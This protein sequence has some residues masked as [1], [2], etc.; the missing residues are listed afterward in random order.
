MAAIH[1]PAPSVCTAG[2]A[3]PP[4]LPNDGKIDACTMARLPIRVKLINGLTEGR[5]AVEVARIALKGSAIFLQ[6]LGVS[7]R[8]RH[9]LNQ[10]PFSVGRSRK[11]APLPH[12]QFASYLEASRARLPLNARER[13]DRWSRWLRALVFLA[14]LGGG[15]WVLWESGQA[16]ARF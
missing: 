10:L 15:S 5:K 8:W 3:G 7:Y 16:L 13:R 11:V 9:L 6:V 12:T 14:A 4:Q 2:D 1:S